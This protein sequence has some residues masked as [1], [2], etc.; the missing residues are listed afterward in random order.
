L[1]S[2]K[3][4]ELKKP[5]TKVVE[6]IDIQNNSSRFDSRDS[7]DDYNSINENIEHLPQTV[8]NYLE[9][10][11]KALLKSK[12]NSDLLKERKQRIIISSRT[13]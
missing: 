1:R 9:K 4:E 10:E 6:L 11:Q 13:H 7:I 5:K 3:K 2:E 12:L 8:S